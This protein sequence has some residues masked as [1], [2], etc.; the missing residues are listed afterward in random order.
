MICPITGIAFTSAAPKSLAP[1]PPSLKAENKRV[2]IP[3]INPWLALSST[4]E[5]LLVALNL[6]SSSL[7]VVKPAMAPPSP[8]VP[9]APAIDF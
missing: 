8:M 3:L 2:P 4:I 9:K 1:A 5:A 7:A 6:P